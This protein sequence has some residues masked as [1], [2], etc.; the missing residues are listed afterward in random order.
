MTIAFGQNSTLA[1]ILIKES[2]T[3][4][5]D[6]IA[7]QILRS[8]IAQRVGTRS[9]TWDCDDLVFLDFANVRIALY[10]RALTEFSSKIVCLAVGPVSR[11]TLPLHINSAKLARTL[12]T[13]FS[14]PVSTNTILWNG[15]D[16]AITS[17]VMDD[18]QSELDEMLHFLDA[19]IRSVA[20]RSNQDPS[21]KTSKTTRLD[22]PEIEELRHH[23]QRSSHVAKPVSLPL[24][25]SLFFFLHVLFH[26][27][28]LRIGTVIL[29]L[30]K[31]W[32]RQTLHAHLDR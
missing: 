22:Q 21:D 12:V 20:N 5:S 2:A 14:D 1:A 28:C 10:D 9:V 4:D 17:A 8:K 11:K 19:Q 3:L 31:R 16:Q 23:L 18:F 27:S 32:G 24:H 7:D 15:L 30:V 29:H 6:D 26:A 25:L 13:L